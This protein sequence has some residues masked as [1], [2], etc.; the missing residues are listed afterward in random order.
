MIQQR[1]ADLGL[2]G[3][4]GHRRL[5]HALFGKDKRRMIQNAAALFLEIL[6]PRPS[7][8][9]TFLLDNHPPL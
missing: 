2:L 9:V 3:D 6:C 7:H 8:G 1:L 4:L 5:V